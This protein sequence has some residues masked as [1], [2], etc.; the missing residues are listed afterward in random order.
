MIRE[1]DKNHLRTRVGPSHLSHKFQ[2]PNIKNYRFLNPD[3]LEDQIK[4]LIQNGLTGYYCLGMENLMP[5]FRPEYRK[6]FPNESNIKTWRFKGV[7]PLYRKVLF[8]ILY[9]EEDANSSTNKMNL[10]TKV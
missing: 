6:A 7:Y 4:L 9:S 1:S 2:G 8:L 5:C 10:S 3:F